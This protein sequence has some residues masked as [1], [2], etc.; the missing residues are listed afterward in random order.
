MKI[1][2]SG[3]G[4]DA[5]GEQT[6]IDERCR[7]QGA[8]RAVSM[9]ELF[10]NHINPGQLHFMKLLGFHKVKIERAEGMYYYD[11]NGRKILDF[12]G[13]FGS[14]ALGHN[15]PRVAGSPQAIPG[16]KAPRNRDCLHVAICSGFGAQYCRLLAGRSRYGVSRL[17]GFRSDGSRDQGCRAR[18]RT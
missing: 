13:G 6:Q 1:R 8:G 12:F 7:R 5:Y 15:H 3:N 2:R 14:L 10:K 16:R 18:R 17:F 9:M 4:P 11:Q